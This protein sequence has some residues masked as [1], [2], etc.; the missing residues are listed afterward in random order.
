MSPYSGQS[1]D[2]N[3]DHQHD[4]TTQEVDVEKGLSTE[5]ECLPKRPTAAYLAT[6]PTTSVVTQGHQPKTLPTLPEESIPAPYREVTKSIP[7]PSNP[8]DERTSRW[9]LLHLWF[10]TYRKFF[11]L[12][13][14][15]NLAAMIAAGLGHFPYAVRN[16][17]AMVLG[18]LLFAVLVRNELFLRFL[19]LVTIYGLR[20]WAPLKIRLAATSALQHIGG[21]HSGCGLSAAVWLILKIIYMIRHRK[22]QHSSVIATGV[23]TSTLICVSVISAFP[24]IRNNHHNAFERYHRFIGWLGVAMTW[25]FVILGNI[26]DAKYSEWHSSG[27]V[28][29]SGQEVW[30][31]LGI[32]ILIA[33]PWVTLRKVPVHVEFPSPRVAIL[34][35][36]RGMQQGLT[37]RISRTAVKEFH[38]FGIVSEG[39]NTP[40]HYMVC[41][42]QGDFT[43]SL[44]SDP[45][46]TVWTRELKFAGIGHASAMYKR[47]IRVCTG[48]GIGASLSTCIQNPNWFLFW[49]GSDQEKTFGPTISG[50]IHKYIEPERMILWD[51]KK[52]GGRPDTLKLLL[53][54]YIEFRAEVV[55]ITSNKLGNDDMMRG[56]YT[57][58]IPAFGTLWDF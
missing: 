3:H 39:V 51:T 43:K 28:L 31:A 58:G 23:V 14:S 2:Y 34:R 4:S 16:S 21:L 40:Y 37:G 12:C 45:P 15:L 32:T 5:L 46:K 55:F 25:V 26:N 36:N 49:I 22:M 47:G 38:A 19:Y 33:I 29:L 53:K 17:G 9:T 35:F 44:V 10:N 8:T 11:V 30:F 1:H 48:T 42:V 50:L 52:R 56:C 27:K 57:A 54:T 6:N 24:W 18:N 7:I 13:T 41:G 20:S